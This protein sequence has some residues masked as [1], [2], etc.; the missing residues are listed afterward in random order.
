M[1]AVTR[2]T[3]SA[4]ISSSS[5]SRSHAKN[6]SLRPSRCQGRADVAR[7]RRLSYRP[8][9][10]VP[11]GTALRCRA[12]LVIPLI[13]T[14]ST[15][16]AARSCP[17]Q[18]R[19]TCS[20]ARWSLSPSTRITARV[21]RTTVARRVRSV[22]RDFRRAGRTMNPSVHAVIDGR[23]CVAMRSLHR[24]TC[25][26]GYPGPVPT[27]TRPRL[28]LDPAVVRRARTPG[29]HGPDGRSSSW[30]SSHTTVSVERATLRLA[31]PGRRRPRARP[32]G[33]P[34][35]RR[36]PRPRSA[37]STASPPRSGTRCAAARPPT[38]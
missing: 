13:G 19:A 28:D 11:S 1:T 2:A 38:C 37:S 7:P 6:G 33:Q 18:D 15:S 17:A 21:T 23:I 30:P 32:V 36:G 16:S 10:R 3:P 14:T 27:T 4:R 20:T 26:H 24:T 31:G 8:V 29:P 12:R 34:P 22:S 35:R 25:G 5:R 9:T